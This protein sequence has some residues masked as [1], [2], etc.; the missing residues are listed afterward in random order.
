MMS[1]GIAAAAAVFAIALPGAAQAQGP[2]GQAST[3]GAAGVGDPYFPAEGNGGYDVRNHDLTL[4]YDSATDHL[5]GLALITARATQTL[6][7]F[8]LDLQGL[9]V[10]SVRVNDVA[11][12]FTR[13]G[14]EL[15]VTP[16]NRLHEHSTFTVPSTTAARRR[17]SS[18]RR[19]CS[20]RRTASCTRTTA[21]SSGR[22]RTPP[23]RGSRA[24]TTRRTRRATCSGSRCPR[25]RA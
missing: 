19:S 16:H 4:G 21:T 22:S 6:G 5:G 2:P 1:R 14:Q 18:A 13:D 24:T 9:D 20:G 7:S 10:H 23:R 25:A 12:Q 11:A 8:H 3:P 15:T 17:R